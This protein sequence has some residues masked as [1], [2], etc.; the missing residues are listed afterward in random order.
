GPPA[1]GGPPPPAPARWPAPCPG[2]RSRTGSR[3]PPPACAAR[4]RPR[5]RS[6]SAGCTAPGPAPSSLLS[7]RLDADVGQERLERLHQAARPLLLPREGGQA[8]HVLLHPPQVG[9]LQA[10]EVLGH[11]LHRL[12]AGLGVDDALV[13]AGDEDHRADV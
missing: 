12:V 2:P 6:A 13:G 4:P 11:L 7:F 1:A 10:L 5:R 3:A 9:P 8:R